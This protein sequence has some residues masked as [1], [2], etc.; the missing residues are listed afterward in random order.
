MG[1][2]TS[3]RFPDALTPICNTCGITL[4]WDISEDEYD[5]NPSF[6]DNW[7]CEDCNGSV[8]YNKQYHK[9]HYK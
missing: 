8:R 2:I 3:K 7:K 6:W 1:I 5:E 9:E 4:C